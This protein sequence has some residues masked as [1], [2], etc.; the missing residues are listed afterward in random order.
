MPFFSNV[1]E[2][3]GQGVTFNS[4]YQNAAHE[5]EPECRRPIDPVVALQCNGT[6]RQPLT[7][8]SQPDA[9]HNDKTQRAH[10]SAAEPAGRL[11]PSKKHPVVIMCKVPETEEGFLKKLTPLRAPSRTFNECALLRV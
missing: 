8:S 11:K 4:S 5:P 7:D 9:I 1:G 3:N 10:L 6:S 2:A